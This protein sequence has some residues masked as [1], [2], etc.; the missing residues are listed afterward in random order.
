MARAVDPEIYETSFWRPDP[1]EEARR[2]DPEILHTIW[3]E[4]YDRGPQ[5]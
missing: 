2:R 4:E 3:H 5:Q 1:V